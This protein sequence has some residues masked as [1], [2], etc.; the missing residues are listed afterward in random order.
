MCNLYRIKRL[1]RASKPRILVAHVDA[2]ENPKRQC[3]TGSGRTNF[4]VTKVIL[5]SKRLADAK[6]LAGET[7]DQAEPGHV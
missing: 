4:R 6:S 7:G 1:H 3:V 2:V 5:M